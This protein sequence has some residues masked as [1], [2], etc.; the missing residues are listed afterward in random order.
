MVQ[1]FWKGLYHLLNDKYELQTHTQQINEVIISKYIRLSKVFLRGLLLLVYD[2]T[3]LEW[4][5]DFQYKYI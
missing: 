5:M 1:S 4:R 2:A 3:T